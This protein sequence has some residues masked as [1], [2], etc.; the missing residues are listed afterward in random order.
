MKYGGWVIAFAAA[1][2]VEGFRSTNG[3]R[4]P[5]CFRSTEPFWFPCSQVPY[6]ENVMKYANG[7]I[8]VVSSHAARDP[9]KEPRTKQAA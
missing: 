5:L 4:Y 1:A 6:V 9:R 2:S 8:V 3:V 7:V